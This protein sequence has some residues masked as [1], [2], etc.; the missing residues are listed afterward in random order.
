[1]NEILSRQGADVFNRASN[2]DAIC[3][4]EFRLKNDPLN[5]DLKNTVIVFFHLPFWERPCG[6]PIP[7]QERDAYYRTSLE[8]MIDSW[9][10]QRAKVMLLAP[11]PGAETQS[12]S[13]LQEYYESL[14][15]EY[16]KSITTGDSGR[17]IRSSNGRYLYNMSCTNAEIC[18]DENGLIGVRLPVDGQHFCAFRDWQGEPCLLSYAGG[19]RRVA[20]AVAEDIVASIR[21]W[22]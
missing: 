5:A 21:S 1:L 15:S 6:F 7:T 2:A 14:R 17:Y 13:P 19:E 11:T 8:S 20:S 18:C 10:A 16:Q 4:I 12:V 22:R 9:I 3:D